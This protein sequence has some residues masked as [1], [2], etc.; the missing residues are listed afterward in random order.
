ME[1][2]YDV[3]PLVDVL[4]PYAIKNTGDRPILILD[5]ILGN[6]DF[7]MSQVYF[8]LAMNEVYGYDIYYLGLS[9]VADVI[10]STLGFQKIDFSEY[11]ATT[12]SL[13]SRIKILLYTKYLLYIKGYWKEKIKTVSFRGIQIGD[14]ILDSAVR[15]DKDLAYQTDFRA[16]KYES[17]VRVAIGN[18]L[19]YRRIF[20]KYKPKAYTTSHR[21]YTTFGIFPKVMVE[22]GET[23]YSFSSLTAYYK[24]INTEHSDY[25]IN[26]EALK[27]LE[28]T[29]QDKIEQFVSQKFAGKVTAFF[30]DLPYKDKKLMDKEEFLHAFKLDGSK[31]T[32]CVMSPCLADSYSIEPFKVFETY[33]EWL[34]FVIEAAKAN[35][36]IN[37]LFKEHPFSIYFEEEGLLNEFLKK[38]GCAELAH[39]TLLPNTVSTASVMQFCDATTTPRGSSAVE[40]FLFDIVPLTTEPIY[41]EAMLPVNRSRSKEEYLKKLS[42][43]TFKKPLSPELKAKASQVL[44]WYS[45]GKNIQPS[46]YE[47]IASPQTPPDEY[48]T[49]SLQLRAKLQQSNLKDDV[50]YKVF[51]SSLKANRTHSLDLH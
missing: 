18:V 28:Q 9:E 34:V 15:F 26:E 23:C 1:L 10:Y 29:G 35:P 51:V 7:L 17:W 30:L 43:V 12:K 8:G 44:Y 36:Q 33:Y 3:R 5:G 38:F 32:I 45:V 4:K 47:V 24:M 21:C 20:D 41:Y 48:G 2:S 42:S 22:R 37:W 39:I 13:K 25:H 11:N 19:M 50:L 40:S 6:P 49:W 46:Y 16:V 31:P 14:L 27:F